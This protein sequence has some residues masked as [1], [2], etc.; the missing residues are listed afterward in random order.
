MADFTSVLS[1]A[2]RLPER[3]R[4]RLID[5]RWDTLPPE[6]EAAI[7][8]EWGQEIERRVA[9]L[10]AGAVETIPWSKIREEALARI[11]NGKGP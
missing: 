3:D 11:N 1:D 4:L 7:S 6:T 9:E 10:D 8:E 2:Q 5:A